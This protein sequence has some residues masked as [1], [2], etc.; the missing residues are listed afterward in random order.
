MHCIV[1]PQLTFCLLNI[2]YINIYT[3]VDELGSHPCR[4]RQRR[5]GRTRPPDRT[6]AATSRDTVSHSISSCCCLQNSSCLP[7]VSRHKF[8]V[9]L[10]TE[11]APLSLCVSLSIPPGSTKKLLIPSWGDYSILFGHCT[12]TPFTFS[13]S[14]FDLGAV[15]EF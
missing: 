10:H 1:V 7:R 3:W 12:C 11:T 2:N 5:R 9:L 4:R 14:M 15:M 8:L 13:C 6:F